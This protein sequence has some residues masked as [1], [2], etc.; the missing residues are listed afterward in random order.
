MDI[1]IVIMLFIYGSVLGSFYGVV[2]DRLSEGKSIVKPASSCTFCGKRLKWYEL[3]PILSFFVQ[4][5]RCNNCHAKLSFF[6]PFVE[7]LTGI[8]FVISYLLFHFSFSFFVSI[9][10]SSYLAII[11]VSDLKYYIIADEV[12]ICFSVILLFINFFFS[13]KE[14]FVDHLLSGILLFIFMYFVS[15][16]GKIIFKKE[17]LGGGDVKLMFFI[18]LFLSIYNGLF[19]VFLASFLAL[20]VSLY[21]LFRKKNSMIAFGPFLLIGAYIVYITGFDILLFIKNLYN[22]NLIMI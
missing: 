2:G 22:L 19:S 7:L 21:S 9:I 1:Y 15:V 20:P 12:T 5:G 4:R 14:Y 8:L 13:Y 18:G 6:Y 11:I 17:C 10:I 3:I 16:F